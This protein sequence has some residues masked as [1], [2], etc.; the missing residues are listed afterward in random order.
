M[1][2]GFI[3]AGLMNLSQAVG[4]IMGANIGTCITAWIVS[5]G[6]L[7]DTF[8]TLSPSLYAPLIVAI[9]SFL[10]MF[11]KK[12]RKQTIGEICIGLDLLFIGLD[13]MGDAKQSTRRFRPL[14]IC[15]LLVRIAP[16]Y[17]PWFCRYSYHA[18]LLCSSW[19]S[20]DTGCIQGSGY[21]QRSSLHQLWIRYRFLFHSSSFQ[22]R[23]QPYGKESSD[24]SSAV[25]RHRCNGL[26]L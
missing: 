8:K 3:N 11:S 6:Q 2:I 9:G 12:E 5:L 23:H 1:I 18:E 10:I 22:Y 4:P 13:F 25:Q 19:Y 21:Y 14:R 15:L 24:D 20:S 16:G 7:G 17:R 26:F